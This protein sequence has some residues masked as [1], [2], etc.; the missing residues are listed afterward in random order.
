MKERIQT[1]EIYAS[2]V[3]PSG[4]IREKVETAGQHVGGI[5]DVVIAELEYLCA[6]DRGESPSIRQELFDRFVDIASQEAIRLIGEKKFAEAKEV[7]EK[8]L[9]IRSIRENDLVQTADQ[10]AEYRNRVAELF[11]EYWHEL[12]RMAKNMLKANRIHEDAASLAEDVLQDS[13]SNIVRYIEKN[14]NAVVGEP[15]AFFKVV[16]QNKARD[17]IRRS[18][19]RN[20]EPSGSVDMFEDAM[21]RNPFLSEE[22]LTPV[23]IAELQEVADF[24]TGK[25][26]E[27]MKSKNFERN[28][29]ILR[30]KL[31]GFSS[32]EI[33]RFL[34]QKGYLK[35]YNLGDEKSR[36]DA[37]ALIDQSFHRMMK[38]AVKDFHEKS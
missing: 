15:L 10:A 12:Y 14:P 21:A 18:K 23:E 4:H 26:G 9:Y 22:V 24:V 6:R 1:E 29:F 8:V 35:T 30:L 32:E 25:L 7:T 5:S 37:G 11:Y 17:Y 19:V 20:T 33:A 31:E 34:Q 38:D 3:D 28:L 16:V 36:V 13:I 27:K 2:D